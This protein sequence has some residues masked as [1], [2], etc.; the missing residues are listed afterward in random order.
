MPYRLLLSAITE[1]AKEVF[2]ENLT[3]VYLHGSA[4]MGCYNPHKSDLDLIFV[5]NE[6]LDDRTKRRFLDRILYLNQKA[7][8]KGLELS[9]VQRSVCNPFLF[10]TPYECHF[11]NAHRAW[12]EQNP[13]EMIRTL[14][15]VD[16]D[17]AAHFTILRHYG[18]VLYGKPISEV[19][20]PV[21]RKDYLNSIR[22]DV[23]DAKEALLENPAYFILNFCRVLG[24]LKEGRILSK[25]S[26]GEW[27]VSTLPACYHPVIRTALRFYTT[28]ETPSFSQTDATAF[29]DYAL[30]EIL[31]E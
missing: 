8:E 19:F 2:A 12:Y 11:S 18:V 31:K 22:A 28:D 10:P 16:P 23:L 25:K 5:V 29:M 15:G 26:G 7:P 3:G 30:N 9:V 6:A 13:E 4:A 24:Y 20:A 14:H 1:M 17:L 27:A 21:P